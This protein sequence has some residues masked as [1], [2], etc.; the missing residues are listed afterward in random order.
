[1]T[2]SELNLGSQ[3]FLI[4]SGIAVIKEP[5]F[6]NLF[7]NTVILTIWRMLMSFCVIV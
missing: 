4:P 5:S 3:D 7:Q 1:M 2:L 6:Q